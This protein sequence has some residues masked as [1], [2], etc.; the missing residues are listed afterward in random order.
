MKLFL[1]YEIDLWVNYLNRDVRYLL[2][3]ASS[4]VACR[5]D[6]KVNEVRKMF[7]LE[8]HPDE[9]GDAFI[10]SDNVD[11]PTDTDI[12]PVVLEGARQAVKAQTPDLTEQQRAAA[13]PLLFS[14]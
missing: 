6:L 11:K 12:P 5:E 14:P 10:W 7:G 4:I 2:N 3:W 9:R 8:P 1:R 13:F